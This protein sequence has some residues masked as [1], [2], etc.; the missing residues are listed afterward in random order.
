MP[1]IGS[2]IFI[3]IIT[4][5]L[6]DHYNFDWGIQT[7]VRICN[8]I[9]DVPICD[10]ELVKASWLIPLIASKAIGASLFIGYALFQLRSTYYI[11]QTQGC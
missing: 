4:V 7:P 11:N 5:I 9:D 1:T 3:I 6:H 2:I 8:M 10:E